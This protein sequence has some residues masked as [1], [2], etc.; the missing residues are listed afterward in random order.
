MAKKQSPIRIKES[1]K[2]SFTSWCKSQGYSGATAQCDAAGKRSKSPSIR[3]KATFSA[4][5]KRW[6]KK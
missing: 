1:K 3:K 4:N 5:S 6:N 2:G